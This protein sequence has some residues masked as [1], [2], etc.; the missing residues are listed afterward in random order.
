MKLSQC[1]NPN[2]AFASQFFKHKTAHPTTQNNDSIY[3]SIYGCKRLCTV[4]TFCTLC[5]VQMGCQ[6]QLLGEQ[7]YL[8]RQAEWLKEMPPLVFPWK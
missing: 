4:C 5:F 3:G 6:T 2:G 7:T 1:T 8:Y